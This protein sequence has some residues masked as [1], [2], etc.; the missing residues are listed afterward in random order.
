MSRDFTLKTWKKVRKIFFDYKLWLL[1]FKK[2]IFSNEIKTFAEFSKALFIFL[3]HRFLTHRL[4]EPAR[5]SAHRHTSQMHKN[6]HFILA[7][8]IVRSDSRIVTFPEFFF[9]KEREEK[10]SGKTAP[11]KW[12][13]MIRS[14]CQRPLKVN[15]KTVQGA[16]VYRNI[17]ET[18]C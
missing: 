13:R 7:K 9:I 18:R 14:E 12:T 5:H 15:E 3:N 8:S 1:N 10:I 2:L 16:E 17:W 11:I 4:S 6:I